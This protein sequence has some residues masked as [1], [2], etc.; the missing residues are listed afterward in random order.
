LKFRSASFDP[1]RGMAGETVRPNAFD[2]NPRRVSFDKSH[3]ALCDK[4]DPDPD[5]RL[6]GIVLT[7]YSDFPKNEAPVRGSSFAET[8]PKIEPEICFDDAR[9]KCAALS[10][11]A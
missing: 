10:A 1:L 8:N 4:M 11:A 3:V 7:G 9:I 6:A 2:H 5:D